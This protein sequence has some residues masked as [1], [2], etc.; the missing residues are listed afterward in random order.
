MASRSNGGL[1]SPKGS[2]QQP[3]VVVVV[4]DRDLSLSHTWKV[5]RLDGA[6]ARDGGKGD[7]ERSEA[8]YWLSIVDTV[9]TAI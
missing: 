3:V 9:E 8:W 5:R 4:L 1:G 6:R 7:S 2:L